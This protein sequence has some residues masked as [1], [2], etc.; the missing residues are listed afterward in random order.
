MFTSKFLCFVGQMDKEAITF[1][2]ARPGELEDVLG[3]LKS[4]A[5]WLRNRN[6]DH[7]QAWL[8]PPPNFVNWVQRGFENEEFHIVEADGVMIGCF[9]LQW[10]DPMFWGLREDAA[11]YVHSFTISRQRV[12]Q[13]LGSKVLSLIE[14]HCREKGKRFLRLDCNA[15]NFGLCR[16]YGSRGFRNV[17]ETTVIGERLILYEKSLV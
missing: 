16:Y 13:G 12:G 1:R 7:W 9:R 11:G 10:E 17:G 5:E 15:G 4:A 2:K 3:L 14:S 8:A 6:I